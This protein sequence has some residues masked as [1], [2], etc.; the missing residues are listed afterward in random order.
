MFYST[1]VLY[2]SRF[3][4]IR[5]IQL[6]NK[7]LKTWLLTIFSCTFKHIS[8][9]Y[10][11]ITYIFFSDDTRLICFISEKSFRE[12]VEKHEASFYYLT[13]SLFNLIIAERI[14]VYMQSSATPTRVKSRHLSV[15]CLLYIRLYRPLLRLKNVLDT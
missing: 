8:I 10:Y 2:I 3:C 7:K 9:A 1:N 13:L 4:D 5:M 6:Y 11:S 12:S 15:H 14:F